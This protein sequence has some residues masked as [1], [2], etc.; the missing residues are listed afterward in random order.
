MATRF[1]IPSFSDINNIFGSVTM[2]EFILKNVKTSSSASPVA[3]TIY[4]QI[5]GRNYSMMTGSKK[6]TYGTTDEGDYLLASIGHG[7]KNRANRWMIV[8]D[9]GS[10]LY[11]VRFLRVIYRGKDMGKSELISEHTHI[12]AEDLMDL[13]EDET[14]MYVTL[15]PRKRVMH[16]FVGDTGV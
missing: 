3:N 11:I 8:Y 4:S 13:F 12:F 1:P 10:D 14:G 9:S 15:M 7:A 16:G 6:L 2:R 5:G